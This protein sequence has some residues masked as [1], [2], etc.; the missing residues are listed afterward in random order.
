MDTQMPIV[1][2][3]LDGFGYSPRHCG[4][5][6]ARAHTPNLDRWF[7]EYP[8]TLLNASG[9]SVGLLEQLPGNSQ[10][11]HLAIGT[12]RIIPQ[13][14]RVIHDAID[15]GLFFSLPLL[16]K[17]F[18]EL[19]KRGATL[20]IMGLLS[21][22]GVHSHTK[23]LYA[24]IE[25]AIQHNIQRI[26]IHP[27]LD[28]RDVVP[29]S[30]YY[31]LEKLE[32]VLRQYSLKTC[33]VIGS[34][35]G[36]FYAMDR[37]NNWDRTQYAYTILTSDGPPSIRNWRDIIEH[38]Y[39]QGVTDEFIPPT[40]LHPLHAVR[41]EDG[42]IFFNIRPDRARQL[43]DAFIDP[44]FTHF[45]RTFIPL[46]CF[47]TPVAYRYSST[48]TAATDVLFPNPV[49]RN[50]LKEVL[51][52]AQK[53]IFSIAET[54]KYAHIT[55]FFDGYHEAAYATETRYLIPSIK[56]KNYV[57]HPQMSAPIITDTIIESLMHK[58]CN[59]YL[60]NYANADMVGHSGNFEA[61][62]QAIECLDN[63]LATLYEH[64]V[65]HNNG[66]LCIT[67]DHGKAEYMYNIHTHEIIT[68]HTTNPVPFLVIQKIS[69]QKKLKLTTLADIAPYILHLMRVPIPPQMHS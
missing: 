53:T 39:Q 28:G 18:K 37:D 9:T 25:A 69:D 48:A 68:A 13:P 24:F 29:R 46:T 35:H 58:L 56:I 44:T 1:L 26:V 57:H 27:F 2:V 23:H 21:D 10:V 30:A 42:I 33:I 59:F 51:A 16:H 38:N 32:S 50:T 63:Q 11:G 15:S 34:I 55:Y 20:H 47:I 36:R 3:I 19:N 22:G 43:T 4:N 67:G 45:E 52:N 8:H 5:A 60:I 14:I 17:H 40:A 61:T 64:V 6:I 41:P 66:T 62:V 65:M 54:E 31:Y 49:I 7:A 12:G